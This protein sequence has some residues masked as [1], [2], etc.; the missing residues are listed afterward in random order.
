[1]R[2]AVSLLCILL[3]MPAS[4]VAADEA[5]VISTWNVGLL[6]RSVADLNLDGF[7]AEIDADILVLN[8]IKTLADLQAIQAALDREEDF[9]AISS[10]ETGSGN[11]E[12]GLISRFPITDVVEFDRSPEN[13]Q[14]S[15]Q[16]R[17]LERVNLPGIADV[18]VGR[19]FLVAH[20]PS[21][22]VVVIVTH[23][24]SSQGRTGSDDL[25]N[26]Q[27]RE[28]VAA[29]I[30]D[31]VN[32]LIEAFPLATLFVLGDFNVG[33]TDVNKNGTDLRSDATSGDGDKYDD[34]HALLKDGLVDELR[35]IPL[36][37][38]LD[39]T[40]VGDD[41]EP[42]F[43]GAGAIDV[44]YVIGPGASWFQ[45]ASRATDRFGSDHLAVFTSTA[46][47]P[48]AGGTPSIAIRKV[49]PNPS[50]PDAGHETITVEN[51]GDAIAIT[52]WMFRDAANNT[53]VIPA[54]TT[55][56]PGETVISL[57]ENTMPL[58]NK[59]DTITLLN[60]QGRQIGPAFSYTQSDVQ[61]GLEIAR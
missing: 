9:S 3:F 46:A 14:V 39:G 34:T 23:L 56:G 12:V 24:K 16:Q 60:E 10:F 27:K 32:E 45:A 42:D 55:L 43:P 49:L 4:F 35:M 37:Q 31:H 36:A 15:P 58:N 57:R 6:D 52:G 59:G 53:F 20:I 38:G 18:G 33:V 7:A 13:N 29:A 5:L 28:L 1:M 26:A 2:M 41:N 51:L 8:E 21:Q 48:P 47:S 61:P 44:I 22:N 19:G 17:R 11:L 50:G 40:F 25:A 54:G 30:A